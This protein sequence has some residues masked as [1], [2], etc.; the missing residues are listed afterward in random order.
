MEI[1]EKELIEKINNGDNVVVDFWAE[2]CGP[3]KM[4]K[5]SFDKVSKEYRESGSN[6]ELYTLNLGEYR[7][8]AMKYGIRSVPTIKSF[9]G[10]EVIDSKMGLQTESQIKELAE[11]LTNV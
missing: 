11:N 2:F 7:E 6:V 3:C 1:S 8:L 5:P 10:G 4:M 9:K